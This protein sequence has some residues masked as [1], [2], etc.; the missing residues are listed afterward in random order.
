MFGEAHGR[1]ITSSEVIV[2][3]I[4]KKKPLSTTVNFGKLVNFLI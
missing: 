4:I 3:R 2:S 1:H